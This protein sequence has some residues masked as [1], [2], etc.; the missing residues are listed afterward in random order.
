MHTLRACPSLFGLPVTRD[1]KYMVFLSRRLE[2]CDAVHTVG[3]QEA[4]R[5]LFARPVVM[6]GDELLRAPDAAVDDFVRSLAVA[7]GLPPVGPGG[8]AWSCYLAMSSASKQSVRDHEESLAAAGFAQRA[9]VLTN[10]A[11][12][13]SH[14]GPVLSGFVPALL[15]SS[16]LWSF[17]KRRLVLPAEHLELQ[18][19]NLWGNEDRRSVVAALLPSLRSTSLKS[20]AGNAMH[21]QSIGSVLMFVVSCTVRRQ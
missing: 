14:M 18:G 15:R 8:V 10:I 4:F 7:R 20:L 11:Q 19:Y 16:L 6:R 13:A 3:V 5:K 12:R 9:A 2:W 21:I 1:R 17:R